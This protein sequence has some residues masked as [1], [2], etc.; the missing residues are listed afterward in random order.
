MEWG[1]GEVYAGL[2]KK[3]PTHELIINASKPCLKFKSEHK[4]SHKYAEN[5]LE[6]L[7]L[8]GAACKINDK[9]CQLNVDMKFCIFEEEFTEMMQSEC[10]RLVIKK[11]KE[12]EVLPHM[13]KQ[14]VEKIS[15]NL[16][17]Y[18]SN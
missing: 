15:K 3:T 1:G 8:C 6:N 2:R 7:E 16:Q 11:A 18:L 5:V 9:D 12:I 10:L 13:K 14:F 4:E 17:S